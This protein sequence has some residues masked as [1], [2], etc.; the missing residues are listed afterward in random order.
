MSR[1]VRRLLRHPLAVA[2]LAVLLAYLVMALFAPYLAPHGIEEFSLRTRL[3]P[4]AGFAGAVPGFPLGTDTLGRDLL[5]RIIW[6]ARVSISIGSL[7]VLISLAVGLTLGA[8]AGYYGGWLDQV[9]SR[10]A[11]LLMAFPYLL[12]TILMMGVLGPG[13]F[14]LILALSFKAWVEFF[15]LARGELLAEKRKDY[16][17]AARAIGRSDTGIIAREI[18]PNIMHTMLVLT[19]LR[20]GY[21]IIVEASLSFLGMG[22][23]PDVPAWGS[24]VASGREHLFE[25]WWVSTVPGLVILVLVLAINALG[26]GLRDVLDPRLRGL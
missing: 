26:E 15:R 25:A 5:S 3:K 2:G 1:N 13:F 24:M 23:P 6:G 14:N 10:A 4:P 16:V 19:T 21:M 8:L 20:L 11:D 9:L 18:L 12:F 7:S 22:V 17:E